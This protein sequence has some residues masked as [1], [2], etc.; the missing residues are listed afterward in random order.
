VIIM[1][2]N[3][4]SRDVNRRVPVG[5]QAMDHG[6]ADYERMQARVMENLKEHFRPEFLNRVD[7]IIVFPQLSEN[8]IL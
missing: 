3:L 4:G 2:T 6:D 5:F 8:E 1:T 7:D